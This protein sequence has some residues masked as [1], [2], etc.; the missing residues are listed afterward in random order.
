MPPDNSS[1]MVAAYVIV[2]VVVVGYFV[3]LWVRVKDAERK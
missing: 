3:S 2:A 1:Y